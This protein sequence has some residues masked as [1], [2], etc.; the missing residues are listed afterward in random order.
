M[1]PNGAWTSP[2]VTEDNLV[3]PRVQLPQLTPLI[4]SC[5]IL[6]SILASPRG[7]GPSIDSCKW[8]IAPRQ[9]RV[10]PDWLRSA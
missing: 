3:L 1:R 4:G 8:T 2:T 6:T 5:L 10:Y 7:C 9:G